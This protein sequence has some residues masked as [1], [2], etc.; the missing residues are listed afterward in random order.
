[1][2]FTRQQGT[3]RAEN[4]ITPSEW[5]KSGTP[6]LSINWLQYEMVFVEETI[7]LSHTTWTNHDLLAWKFHPLLGSVGRCCA[8]TNG[9]K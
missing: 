3:L 9:E 1:V 2:A 8:A 7:Y 4:I 5:L 6:E